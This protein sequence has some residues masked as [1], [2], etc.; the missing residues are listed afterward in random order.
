MIHKRTLR[1]G[2]REDRTKMEKTLEAEGLCFERRDNPNDYQPFTLIVT[3]PQRTR[4]TV[5]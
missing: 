2:M 3:L 4:A 1:F 5:E